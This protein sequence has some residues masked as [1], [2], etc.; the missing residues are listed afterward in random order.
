MNNE[1][2]DMFQRMFDQVK[3]KLL[4]DSEIKRIERERFE[5]ER[6]QRAIER[7]AAS[8]I[9]RRFREHGKTLEIEN[10]WGSKAAEIGQG[11]GK[12]MLLLLFGPPG[13]GK[14]QLATELVR[15]GITDHGMNGY[16]L[17]GYWLKLAVK[18]SW[19]TNSEKQLIDRL[20]GTGILVI[21]EIDWLFGNKETAT[22]DY[23][24]SSFYHILNCRYND[25]L[26]TV[27]TSNRT[28]PELKRILPA[29]VWGRINETGGVISTEGWIDWRAR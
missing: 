17:T 9:P 7:L 1:V 29:P 2:N 3:D 21:D 6:D 8:G 25:M 28:L 16:F 23:W 24:T 27:L 5:A 12:G 13:T 15:K 22:E 11:V 14:T 10:L 4:S 18:D 20:R 26:D 19:S